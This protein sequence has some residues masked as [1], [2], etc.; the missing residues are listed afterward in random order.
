MAV[1]LAVSNINTNNTSITNNI[2]DI[3]SLLGNLNNF[4]FLYNVL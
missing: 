3:G 4:D 1:V 2:L